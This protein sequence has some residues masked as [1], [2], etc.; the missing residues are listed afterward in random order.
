MLDHSTTSLEDN[1]PRL[2]QTHVEEEKVK[3]RLDLADN[4]SNHSA[5]SNSS[6]R[7]VKFHAD[8]KQETER[9]QT[10]QQG[11]TIDLRDLRDKAAEQLDQIVA[12]RGDTEYVLHLAD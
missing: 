12:L 4:N 7:R 11:Q 10:D 8:P 6:S 9:Q 3:Q 1:A 2:S 5:A